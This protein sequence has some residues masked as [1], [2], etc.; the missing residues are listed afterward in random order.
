[1][2]DYQVVVMGVSGCGKSSVGKLL[3]QE[4]GAKF[5]DGDDLHP[6]ANIEKMAAGVSL[7]DQDRWPWLDLVGQ[8]LADSSSIVVACSALKRSYRDRILLAA[9]NTWFVHLDGS[10]ELLADRMNS[11]GSHFMKPAMLESQLS[12]LEP[13]AEDEPGMVYDISQPPADI[14]YKVMVDLG[15]AI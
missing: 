11:R 6:K 8:T 5:V 12:T 9:P 15:L 3:A 10:A 14:V 1:M 4:I 13:L 2:T 7:N